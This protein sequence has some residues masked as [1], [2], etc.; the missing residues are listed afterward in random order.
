MIG[1]SDFDWNASKSKILPGAIVE[2]FTSFG[3]IISERNG[4]TPCTE[5]IANGA[6]GTSGTVTE[7]YALQQKFPTAFMQVQYC[8]GWSLAESYYQSLSGPYQLL[9]IGDPLCRP[10][11]KPI[12]PAPDAPITGRGSTIKTTVPLS[13][14]S[15]DGDSLLGVQV[16]CPGATSIDLMNLGRPVGHI[17]GSK[18]TIQ[19]PASQLGIGW[20]SLV[21]V[22]HLTTHGASETVAG[23]RIPMDIS[24]TDETAGVSQSAGE[25]L[26][27]GL[28]LSIEGGTPIVVKDTFDGGWLANLIKEPG[29]HF[30]LTGYFDVAKEDLYQVQLKTN[31]GAV[32]KISGGQ[33]LNA[34]DDKQLFA[35]CCW[36]QA[37]TVYRSS[38]SRQPTRSSTSARLDRR[39][40]PLRRRLSSTL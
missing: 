29:K 30:T 24:F 27:P 28:A 22:A 36:R 20:I 3:G 5:F 7:P 2:H 26:A 21:P 39:A 12:K 11:A 13:Y 19:V 32:V 37:G 33:V 10:W 35:R 38:A 14:P 15:S 18:G 1:I 9:I 34:H 6:S 16:A 8:R 23:A 31:T 40:A 25:T 17:Q 4:Q